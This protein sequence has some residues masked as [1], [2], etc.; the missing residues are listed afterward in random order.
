MTTAT[1][2]QIDRT[3]F[4]RAAELI[5]T[6]GFWQMTSGEEKGTRICAGLA[7]IDA[8]YETGEWPVK[9]RSDQDPFYAEFDYLALVLGY[10]RRSP[11][12][13]G[14]MDY[15]FGWNDSTSEAEV[16]GVLDKL[17]RRE[18]L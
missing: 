8:K 17:A 3:R 9:D 13:G 18:S 1:E 5:R 10:K 12:D 14:A 16:L 15:V 2:V 11:L 4:A 6:K 7:L